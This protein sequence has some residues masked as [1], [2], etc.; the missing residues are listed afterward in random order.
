MERIIVLGGHSGD[1]A[2]TSGMA[3]ATLVRNG[4]KVLFISL[5]NGDGGKQGT[6][7]EVYA[8]Q[9]ESEAKKCCEILGVETILFPIS[10]GKLEATIELQEQLATIFRK[11]KPDTIITHFK[12]TVHR[13]HLMTSILTKQA[14]SLA[15]SSRYN[16]GNEPLKG[17]QLLYADNW[18]D[19]KGFIPNYY[20][21][22]TEE[23][24]KVWLE[25]CSQFEFFR[26]SFYNFNY[27]GYYEALHRMRGAIGALSGSGK[28][29]ATAFMRD[30]DAY[31]VYF[32]NEKG[33]DKI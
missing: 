7:R 32:L 8:V 29:L 26:C 21:P 13:D 4:A 15:E 2:I 23:D 18:E 16:D 31:G 33:E 19:A 17:A 27:K 24:E 28:N 3:I 14:K 1:E 10:S 9:K 11:F 6:P 20:L 12:E 25:A 30:Y 5:T 22:S